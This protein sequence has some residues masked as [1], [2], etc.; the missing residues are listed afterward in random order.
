MV[1]VSL[2]SFCKNLTSFIVLFFVFFFLTPLTQT[3][4]PPEDRAH[5]SADRREND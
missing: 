3:F 2:L 1:T 4:E 5:L